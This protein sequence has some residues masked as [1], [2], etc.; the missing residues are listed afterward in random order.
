MHV[1]IA[2]PCLHLNRLR[3]VPLSRSP[4]SETRKKSQKTA[5]KN[6]PRSLTFEMISLC[7]AHTTRLWSPVNNAGILEL[8]PIESW[9][10]MVIFKRMA[11]VNLWGMIDVT[12]TFLALV[13]KAQGRVGNSSSADGNSMLH[14]LGIV[15]LFKL[16]H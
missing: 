15:L 3:V 8:G 14:L 7:S 12:K 1:P 5:R 6:D 10:R 9:A 13:K 2:L 16:L 4:S 11:D